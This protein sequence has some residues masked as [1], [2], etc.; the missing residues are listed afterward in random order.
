MSNWAEQAP[1]AAAGMQPPL[2]PA[3]LWIARP[4]TP[5]DVETYVTAHEVCMLAE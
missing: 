2:S 4:M 1:A 3:T 5:A